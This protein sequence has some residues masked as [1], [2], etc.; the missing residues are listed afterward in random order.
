MQNRNV[1]VTGATGFVGHHLVK[2]LV[3]NKYQVT[4]LTRDA[5]KDRQFNG[6]S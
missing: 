3:E 6:T 5:E 2:R 1:I 4:V